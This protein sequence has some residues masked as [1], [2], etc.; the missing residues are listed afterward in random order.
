[1]LAGKTQNGFVGNKFPKRPER[2]KRNTV[3]LIIFWF[4]GANRIPGKNY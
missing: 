2:Y 3:S 1:M 4:S